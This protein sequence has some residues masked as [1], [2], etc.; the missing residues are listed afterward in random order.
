MRASSIKDINKDIVSFNIIALKSIKH[1]N[2]MLKTL[3][4][5]RFSNPVMLISTY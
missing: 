3:V 1:E 2:D 4:K 5:E